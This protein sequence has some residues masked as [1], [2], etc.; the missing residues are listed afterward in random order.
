MVSALA[1]AKD[2]ILLFFAGLVIGWFLREATGGSTA[3]T[4]SNVE[5][6]EMWEDDEGRLHAVVHRK[7]KPVE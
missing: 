7:V 1:D 4:I 3:K 6:W 2:L 5:S